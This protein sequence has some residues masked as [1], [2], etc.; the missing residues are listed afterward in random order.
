MLPCHA[1]SPWIPLAEL[2]L[3]WLPAFV[4]APIGGFLSRKPKLSKSFPGEKMPPQGAQSQ[5]SREVDRAGTRLAHGC[6]PSM[7]V[8]V[9][10]GSC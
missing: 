9:P 6:A 2:M 8:R 3:A 1:L 7:A 4:S 5:L 10:W